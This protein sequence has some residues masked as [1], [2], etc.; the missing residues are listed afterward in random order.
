MK[1]GLFEMVVKCIAIGSRIMGDD[2]IGI[3]VAEI[4]SPQLREEKI[5]TI[6]GEADAD[7]AL[8]QIDDED[9]LFI[10]DSTYFQIAPGTVTYTSIDE[11]LILQNQIYSQHQPNLIQ[12]IKLSNK[13]IKGF[14]IGIEVEDI[15]FGLGLTDCLKEKLPSI[16]KEISTFIHHCK[17]NWV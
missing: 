17:G 4:L 11:A 13:S 3:K 14:I 8:R 1:L 6:I 15:S 12:L 5:E 16:C 9:F 2:S 10:L 7:Y